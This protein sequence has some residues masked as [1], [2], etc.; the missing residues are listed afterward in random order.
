MIKN[1]W[2]IRWQGATKDAQVHTESD[3]V[4]TLKERS[5]AVHLHTCILCGTKCTPVAF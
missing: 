1:L 3:I 2:C 4:L 5:A